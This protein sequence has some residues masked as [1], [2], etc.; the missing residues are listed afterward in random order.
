MVFRLNACIVIK[1]VKHLKL[2]ENINDKKKV[3]M[4]SE[5]LDI[6]GLCLF[7]LTSHLKKGLLLLALVKN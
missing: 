4:Y 5:W 1:G 7:I 3:T 2:A 6:G